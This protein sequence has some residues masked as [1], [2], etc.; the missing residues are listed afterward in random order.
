MPAGLQKPPLPG[1]T[2]AQNSIAV[3]AAKQSPLMRQA[4]RLC[5]TCKLGLL[6]CQ[7]AALHELQPVLNRQPAHCASQ[8]SCRLLTWWPTQ[9][10][11]DI[12][13][14]LSAPFAACCKDALQGP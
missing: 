3:W 2:P 5:Y 8:S 14:R 9:P 13:Q 10:A 4:G 1:I 7:V 6:H 11:A 12:H